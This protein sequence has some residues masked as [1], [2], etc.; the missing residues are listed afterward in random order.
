MHFWCLFKKK[1]TFKT[2]KTL[3][4]SKCIHIS[5]GMAFVS[6]S[7]ALAGLCGRPGDTVFLWSC[8]CCGDSRRGSV[9]VEVT[10][11]V[12]TRLLGLLKGRGL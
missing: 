8:G 9:S 3:S 2:E 7:P 1:T 6:F 10:K 11:E 4:A 5:V 12:V